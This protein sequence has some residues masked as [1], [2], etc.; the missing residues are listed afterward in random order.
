MTPTKPFFCVAALSV[1]ASVQAQTQNPVPQQGEIAIFGTVQSVNKAAPEITILASRFSLP[2]GKNGSIAPPKAK[3]IRFGRATIIDKM[4]LR[5]G[6]NIGAIGRDAGSGRPLDA[7][8]LF[9]IA[10]LPATTSTP[11]SPPVVV[12]KPEAVEVPAPAQTTFPFE[13][14][15]GGW[16]FRVVDAGFMAAPIS[17]PDSP[18]LYGMPHF[19]VSDQTLAP[20]GNPARP[21]NY[22]MCLLSP[23]GAPLVDGEV[24]PDWPFVWADF[25]ARAAPAS[26]ETAEKLADGQSEEFA[27][28]SVARP[29]AG[30]TKTVDMKGVTPSGIAVELHKIGLK[31]DGGVEV[32]LES[33]FSVPASMVDAWVDRAMFHDAQL[34]GADGKVVFSNG[35]GSSSTDDGFRQ[36][37]MRFEKVPPG[38]TWQL[39]LGYSVV[40]RSKALGE[41]IGARLKIPVNATPRGPFANFDPV[42]KTQN[43][44]V[45]VRLESDAMSWNEL[46]RGRLWTRDAKA[47]DVQWKVSKAWWQREGG[48]LQQIWPQSSGANRSFFGDGTRAGI[49]DFQTDLSILF[50]PQQRPT[51]VN[52]KLELQNART[53]ASSFSIEAPVPA[54]NT[55]VDVNEDVSTDSNAPFTLERV[56]WF[57]PSSPL[58][59]TNTE[60]LPKS[61]LALVFETTPLLPDGWMLPE[62]SWARDDQGRPLRGND[63]RGWNRGDLTGKSDANV[64]HQTLILALPAPGAKTISLGATCRELKQLGETTTVELRG[65]PVP[66][67]LKR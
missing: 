22:E 44:R 63:Y 4:Q 7:R 24:N 45:Q 8:T 25:S 54:P 41:R 53:Y 26:D 59:T 43:D 21:A 14:K 16:T 36:N 42:V 30:E 37:T 60:G 61:G 66:P 38:D 52:L 18:A 34:I 33:R 28:F 47:R 20:D 56:V 9:L 40:R 58:G 46:W 67:A 51:N 39:Q 5:A 3:T 48:Q 32:R 62:L 23:A 6:M 50:G 1:A 15:S 11:V 13:V 27:N 10:E 57:S 35:G 12:S 29:Q 2:S 65:A 49:G 19:Q 17:R 55:S 31:T 64:S